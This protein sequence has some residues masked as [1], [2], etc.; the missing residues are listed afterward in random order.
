MIKQYFSNKNTTRPRFFYGY[1]LVSVAVVIQVIAWGLYNSY[2]VF[3]NQL[4]AD[5]AWPRETISGAF[6]LAQMVIGVGAIFLGTL[7]DRYGPRLLM[8][9]GGILAG[10]GYVLMSQVNSVWQLYLF[11]GVIVGI[12]LSGT[13]VILLSTTA[14]WFIK[15]RG[16]MSGVVKMGTGIGIM[17][18]PIIT[19]GLIDSYAWRTS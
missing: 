15:R 13:D 17:L 5:F 7:N 12:G 2:G 16:I 18:I 1:I 10:L 9:I 11:Y 14:R 8:T 3:F 6:S 19:A 4:L